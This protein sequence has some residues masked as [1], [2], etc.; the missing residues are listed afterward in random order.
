[1]VFGQAGECAVPVGLHWWQQPVRRNEVMGRG[2]CAGRGHGVYQR[3]QFAANDNHPFVAADSL[4]PVALPWHPDQRGSITD[5]TA[6]T[7]RRRIACGKHDLIGAHKAAV[8]KC[9]IPPCVV[10]VQ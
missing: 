3:G 2:D 4:N 1:M 9:D 5:I 8:I 7:I 10:S 6:K